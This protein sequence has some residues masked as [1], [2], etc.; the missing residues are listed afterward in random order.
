MS[1]KTDVTMEEKRRLLIA[2]MAPYTAE[3]L[4]PF[5]LQQKLSYNQMFKVC[6]LSLTLLPIRLLLMAVVLAAAWLTGLCTLHGLTENQKIGLDPISGW[7]RW[8]KP[9]IVGLAR[10]MFVIGGWYW[11]PHK[12]QRASR[13]E[14]PILLVMP[15]SSFLDTVVVIA[16]G[17][18]SMVATD[19]TEN[20][21]FFGTLVNYMQPLYIKSN[22]P[23]SRRQISRDILSRVTSKKDFEQLLIFPEGGCGNRRALLQF[24]LGGFSPGVPVQPVFI[25]YRNSTDTITWSWDGPSGWKQLWLTLSQIYIHCELEFLPV[26]RPSE[27]E[28]ANPRL[29]ADN[30]QS[31]VSRMTGTP[32]TKFCLEDARYLNIAKNMQLPQTAAMAKFLRLQKTVGYFDPKEEKLSGKISTIGDANAFSVYLGLERC[33][34][35][36][37]DFSRL[38]DQ[39]HTGVIDFRVYVATLC[40]LRDDLTTE[41]KLQAAHQILGSKPDEHLATLLLI[42]KG[43]PASVC[44]T[45]AHSIFDHKNEKEDKEWN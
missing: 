11:I 45:T 29:F 30:V 13:E 23:D 9:F 15:H 35:V 22:N 25:R 12:G 7:R 1:V 14:A 38:I 44:W 37:R 10:F 4:N 3:I 18:P 36:V 43:I 33:P 6:F 2:E 19:A 34:E 27:T 24:K 20:A 41:G 21:P 32:I 17:C 5:S 16:L 42:W 39:R 31:Y 28:R 8:A 26:Y 40:L